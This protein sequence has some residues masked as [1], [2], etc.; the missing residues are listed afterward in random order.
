MSPYIKIHKQYNYG[1]LEEIFNNSDVLIVPSIW[2]ETF[3]F[4]VLEALCHGVPVIISETV[5]AKD[6]LA[7][8]AGIVITEM[9]TDKLYEAIKSLDIEKLTAMNQTILKKQEIVDLTELSKLIEKKCY[10]RG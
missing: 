2:Y 5:G 1:E 9:A 8:G 4:T 3:G 10:L 6:I 7:N